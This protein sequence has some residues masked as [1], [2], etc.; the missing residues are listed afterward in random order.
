MRTHSGGSQPREAALGEQERTPRI[1]CKSCCVGGQNFPDLSKSV[2]KF[3]S[4]LIW[5]TGAF[6]CAGASVD[7]GVVG[8]LGSELSTSSVCWDPSSTEK[9]GAR[10]LPCA[11]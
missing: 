3:A 1:V 8:S 11:I 4:G 10:P 2:V 5:E 6:E 9:A 7:R